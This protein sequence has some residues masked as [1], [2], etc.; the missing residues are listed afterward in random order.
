M[1]SFYEQM[2]TNMQ[3]SSLYNPMKRSE[4]QQEVMGRMQQLQQSG[5]K[6]NNNQAHWAA[7]QEATGYGQAGDKPQQKY[8]S[9]I[10]AQSE[11]YEQKPQQKMAGWTDAQSERYENPQQKMAGYHKKM[12][13]EMKN[14]RPGETGWSPWY[15]QWWAKHFG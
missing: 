10:D 2:K 15:N 6:A 8:T 9:W 5:G 11:R 3:S 12:N 1:A 13:D 4:Y 7:W 14:N